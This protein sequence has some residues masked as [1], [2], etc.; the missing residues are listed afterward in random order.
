M[1]SGMTP[2][3]W[4]ALER[5]QRVKYPLNEG[6]WRIAQA[7]QVRRE[8]LRLIREGVITPRYD[9]PTPLVKVDG[10]WVSYRILPS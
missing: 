4:D 6:V 2:R 5:S 7:D 10:K 9:G 3:I 1:K 8:R